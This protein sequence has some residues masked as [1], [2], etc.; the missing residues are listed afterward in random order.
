[1]SW[2]DFLGQ[3]FVIGKG[4]REDGPVRE[5]VMVVKSLH[6]DNPTLSA[7]GMGV[8]VWGGGGGDLYSAA[9]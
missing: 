6:R 2:P 8:C 3:T 5:T 7:W 1:M 4:L 9:R